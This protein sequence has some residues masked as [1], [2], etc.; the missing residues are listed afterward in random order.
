MKASRIKMAVPSLTKAAIAS[1]GL[2]VGAACASQGSN[3]I[4]QA[5]I[6]SDVL[7]SDYR[8]EL[9]QFR[10]ATLEDIQKGFG[11]DWSVDG[12]RFVLS[13]DFRTN[14]LVS[15]VRLG[16]GVNKEG[17]AGTLQ[18][19]MFEPDIAKFK[20]QEPTLYPDKVSTLVDVY[21]SVL[22]A[23][24]FNSLL[25]D[26]RSAGILTAGS[27]A[28]TLKENASCG[29]ASHGYFVE[30]LF[31]GHER[32]FYRSGCGHSDYQQSSRPAAPLIRLA[33]DK[34]PNLSEGL[35]ENVGFVLGEDLLKGELD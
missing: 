25:D 24:E 18:V 33:L 26:L 19:I 23:E 1:L 12:V 31:S 10:T 35:L 21:T 17:Q 3:I 9:T 20:G 15:A 30:S 13:S 2:A 7:S 32:L 29:H 4:S 16:L 14:V 28:A 8:F 6:S 5:E 34:M 27:E 22:S 11:A